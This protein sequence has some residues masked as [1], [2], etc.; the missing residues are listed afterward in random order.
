MKNS[1]VETELTEET[2]IL[3]FSG[4]NAHSEPSRLMIMI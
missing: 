2:C 1:H 4:Q 3:R